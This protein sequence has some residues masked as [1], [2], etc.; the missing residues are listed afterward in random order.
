MGANRIFKPDWEENH[1]VLSL[2]NQ[3]NW[4]LSNNGWQIRFVLDVKDDKV[5]AKLVSFDDL[6]YLEN[7]RVVDDWASLPSRKVPQKE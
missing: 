3:V 1:P 4:Q 5:T 7:W 6:T 2:M